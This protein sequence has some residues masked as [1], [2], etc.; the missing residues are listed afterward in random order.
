MTCF[1]LLV[2]FLKVGTFAFGGAYS[3]IPL[4]A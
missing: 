3:A 2:G 4:N 1:D